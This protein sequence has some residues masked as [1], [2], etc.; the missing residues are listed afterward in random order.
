MSEGDNVEVWSQTSISELSLC[1]LSALVASPWPQKLKSHALSKIVRM[2]DDPP[3]SS[4]LA[5]CNFQET[6]DFRSCRIPIFFYLDSEVES[7]TSTCIN[8]N[9]QIHK[10][11]SAFELVD[12][13]MSLFIFSW[14]CL[15]KLQGKALWVLCI[16]CHVELARLCG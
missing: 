8:E 10:K 14:S 11:T 15:T 12:V 6:T 1:K 5:L 13:N 2:S 7:L 16:C 9:E 3:S 4:S